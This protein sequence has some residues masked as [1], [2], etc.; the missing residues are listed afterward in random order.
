MKACT[1]SHSKTIFHSDL[2]I[3]RVNIHLTP[4]PLPPGPVCDSMFFPLHQ[5]HLSLYKKK[6]SFL[7]GLPQP[8]LTHSTPLYHR[9]HQTF[10]CTLSL[11]RPSAM[12]AALLFS[13]SLF[14]ALAPSLS[15]RPRDVRINCGSTEKSTIDGVEWLPDTGYI[16]SGTPKNVTT[17]DLLRTLATVRTFPLK[18]NLFKKFCYEIPVVPDRT[19]KYMVRT[20]YFYGE[21]GGYS[22]PRPPVFDQIVDGTLWAVVNTTEDY[23]NGNFIYYEGI[24]K[25]TGKNLSVCLA[26][27]TYTDSDPF[28][29]SL[30]VVPLWDQLYN[31]TDFHTYAL[32]LVARH[33]FGFRG[34]IIKYPDDQFDRYWV[35]FGESNS[36]SLSSENVSVPGIWNLPPVRVFQTRLTK[37]Q[38]EPLLLMWPPAYL[39]NSTYYVALYFADDRVSTSSRMFDIT[40]NGI[41]YYNNLSV[42]PAGVVVFAN[43]WPL[44]GLTNIALTPSTGS[45][46]GP[47][48]NAGEVF[49]VLTVGGK[50]LA[51]DVVAMEGL[52]K[53]FQNP[54]VDWNGDPC[55]PRQY[56]WT[57]VTCSE[58]PRI[59]I[60]TLNMTGMGLS[61]LISP[62]ISKMTAL[63]TILLGN[64]SL[65]GTIPDLSSLKGL[66]ILHLE[67]N[68]LGGHIPPLLGNLKNL[69]ELFV[70]N[71]N[72]TGQVPSNISGKPGLDLR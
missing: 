2:V 19:T 61:G 8:Q 65:S 64:N 34:S 42:T 32:S 15:Q 53:S 71:N 57:G 26:A 33:S 23:M 18:N 11:S 49:Q 10:F 5:L 41:T 25:P 13:L 20:A 1:L 38:P 30:E 50:T 58:G 40:I 46:I 21:I 7:V 39:P 51:R 24:F 29:S 37:E 28:I 48:I 54:P 16:S 36:P 17:K 27:N 9:L 6:Y 60:V 45:S 68:R 3:S 47:L 72:L 59:R 67:D 56:S 44:S 70:Y 63:T 52:K 66:T 62:Y 31:S 22:N 69:R 14:S 43:Q 55:L 4:R 35:P 12:I